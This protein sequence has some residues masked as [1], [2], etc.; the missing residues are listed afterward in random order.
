MICALV[1]GA[2]CSGSS[3]AGQPATSPSPT[4]PAASTSPATGGARSLD[5]AP[6]PL[7]AGR[8]TKPGFAPAV[9]FHVTAGWHAVQDV[10][11]FFDVERQPGSLDVIAVQF[12][13]PTGARTAREAVAQLRHRHGLVVRSTAQQRIGGAAAVRIVVDNAD[14]DLQAQRFADAL[15]VEAGTLSLG[16]GRRLQIDLID[17]S[18]GLLAILVGG[19]VRRWASTQRVAEPVV[20]SVRLSPA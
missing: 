4:S 20:R 19:S 5:G 3:P 9:S 2:G 8:Y 17:T 18:D 14:P 12:A 15:T 13:R 10:P 1:C 7:P 11:G 6:D 16:S